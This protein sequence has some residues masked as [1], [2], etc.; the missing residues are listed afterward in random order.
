[1]LGNSKNKHRHFPCMWGQPLTLDRPVLQLPDS[2][3]LQCLVDSAMPLKPFD[4]SLFRML[5][6]LA[7]QLHGFGLIAGFA[8]VV[9][10]DD[11]FDLNGYHDIPCSDQPC[12][13][14]SLAGS[15]HR[16]TS[17]RANL[18]ENSFDEP[19]SFMLRPCGPWR[20][21]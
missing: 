6:N 16:Q 4:I 10:G 20:F 11:G 15:C 3:G 14:H 5:F 8:A 18:S 21:G 13:R 1:M 2:Y 12:A 9:F 17:F 19:Y 7:E